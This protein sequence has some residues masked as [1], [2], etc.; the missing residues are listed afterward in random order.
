MKPFYFFCSMMSISISDVHFCSESLEL[1]SYFHFGDE[2]YVSCLSLNLSLNLTL[3]LYALVRTVAG[4]FPI[5]YITEVSLWKKK[6]SREKGKDSSDL[7]FGVG[8]GVG[9]GLGAG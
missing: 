3:T 4:I 8:V 9:A 2:D 1:F 7:P 6:R 5:S